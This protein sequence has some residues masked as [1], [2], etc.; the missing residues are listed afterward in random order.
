MPRITGT[1][2]A[3][4]AAHP[5]D[6][7]QVGQRV[8]IAEEFRPSMV[9]E[10]PTPAATDLGQ[11]LKKITENDA[12]R[13]MVDKDGLS[14]GPFDGRELVE[15]IVKGEILEEHVLSNM[16]TGEKKPISQWPEFRDF[17]EQQ[18][19]R[20]RESARKNAL[21]EAEES[22]KRSG[23]TKLIVGGTILAAIVISVVVFFVTRGGGEDEQ[24]ASADV[25]ELFAHGEIEIEG[26]AGILPDPP[27]RSGGGGMR[28]ASGGGGGG[29]FAGS[30]EDAMN[31]A[32][33]L[34]DATMGGGQ[35]RLSP[36]QVSGVMNRHVNRI[37]QSCVVPE[38]SRGGRLGNVTI[39]IAIGGNGGVMG[40]SARQGSGAFKSCVQRAVRS[41]RFPSFGAPRMGARYSFDAS[42]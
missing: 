15:L 39:D 29:G 37:Y 30:Y 24:V 34:G 28:R 8:S 12:P 26:T 4:A 38:A 13:W 6:Q 9:G 22:E 16:D 35:G 36:A 33:E 14:H 40:V 5:F 10:A 42:P 17:V 2:A 41:V 11:V 19:L 3:M 32:V 7:P 21:I 25:G 20:A 23:A 27:R 31:R 1:P 18:K